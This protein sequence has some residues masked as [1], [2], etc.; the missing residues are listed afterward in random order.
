MF[1][2]IIAVAISMGMGVIGIIPQNDNPIAV[3]PKEVEV[4]QRKAVKRSRG[5]GKG[6]VPHYAKYF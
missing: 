1:S 3:M 5:K 4:P 2:L 6:S